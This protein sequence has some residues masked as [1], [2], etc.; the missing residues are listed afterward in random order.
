MSQVL[1]IGAHGKIARLATPRLVEAGHAVTGVIRK[2]EQSEAVR[3]LG[4]TPLVA[5]VASLSVAEI[6]GVVGDHDVVLWAAGAGGGSPERTW[7][8]DRDA[9]IR[10]V[11][12][13][14]QAGA[15]RFVMISYFGAGPDHGVEPDSDFFAY[16]E[17]KTQ[18]DAHLAATDLGWTILRPSALTDEDGTGGIETGAGVS[19]SQVSRSTV[20]DVVTAVVDAPGAAGLTLEFNDGDRPVADVITG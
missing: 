19:A 17:S 1:I 10:T 8:V 5:D 14:S 6:A 16:A 15:A 11:D 4:A 2:D 7:S 13:A 12:A 9:A 20:A 18:A 3:S